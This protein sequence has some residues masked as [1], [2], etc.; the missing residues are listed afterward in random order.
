LFKSGHAQNAA[1][2]KLGFLNDVTEAEYES[3]YGIVVHDATT[4][5]PIMTLEVAPGYTVQRNAIC[6]RL[7][8]AVGGAY[9]V[10]VQARD[11]CIADEYQTIVVGSS[12][13]YFV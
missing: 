4:S 9:S 12:R 8:R 7:C 6:C 2:H 11:A 3:A 10:F 5:P 1:A 13:M